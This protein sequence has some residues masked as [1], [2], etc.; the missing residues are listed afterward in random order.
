MNLNLDWMTKLSL[1][2]IKIYNFSLN[3]QQYIH[4]WDEKAAK[5]I[6]VYLRAFYGNLVSTVDEVVMELK[7][8]NNKNAELARDIVSCSNANITPI[9]TH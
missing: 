6:P 9:K 8:Q 7:I 1:F 4:R 5:Q 2:M 3:L